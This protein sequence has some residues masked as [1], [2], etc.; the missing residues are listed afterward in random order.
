MITSAIVFVTGWDDWL[1]L[2]I[3]AT[4]LALVALLWQ[5]I[6]PG[7]TKLLFYFLNSLDGRLLFKAFLEDVM[8]DYIAQT[9]LAVSATRTIGDRFEAFEAIQT[10]HGAQLTKIN[11]RMN[12]LPRMSESMERF[13]IAIDKLGDSIELINKSVAKIDGRYEADSRARRRT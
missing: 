13:A 2:L 5:A 12:D 6:R 11:D 7:I 9:A 4:V 8:H 10:Q 3:P 1:K